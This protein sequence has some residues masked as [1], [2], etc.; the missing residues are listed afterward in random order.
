MIDFAGKEL[1]YTD[2]ATGEVIKCPVLV[3]VLPFSGYS[4]VEALASQRQEDFL[5]GIANA[6]AYLGGVTACALIDNLKSGVKRANRYE[7]VFTDLL[8]QM[9]LHYGCTFI[10]TRVRT[11]GPF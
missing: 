4:Y 3:A 11:P 7:P 9:S 5:R 2:P 10:A 8:E 6:F 1:C